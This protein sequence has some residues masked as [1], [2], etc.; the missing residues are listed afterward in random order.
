MVS[1]EKYQGRK[2]LHKPL[3][4][5]VKMHFFILM[6]PHNKPYRIGRRAGNQGSRTPEGN[7]SG[8]E[9]SATGI[10]SSK[11]D[12]PGHQNQVLPNPDPAVIEPKSKNK[13]QKWTIEDYKNV[14]RAYN[15]A[16]ENPTDTLTRQTLSSGGR[17]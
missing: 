11:D 14:I 5:K 6:K 9:K 3:G 13:R 17:W 12:P 7:Q 16:Q 10:Q 8:I 15:I 1:L 4:S 2:T